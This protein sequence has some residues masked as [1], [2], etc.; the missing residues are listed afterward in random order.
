MIWLSWRGKGWIAY[1]ILIPVMIL[2][3]LMAKVFPQLVIQCGASGITGG[4]FILGGIIVWILGRLLNN[5]KPSIELHLCSKMRMEYMGLIWIACGVFFI[6][7][8][9]VR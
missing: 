4:L 2:A 5:G 1:A 9:T 8:F 3:I 6:L 7:G